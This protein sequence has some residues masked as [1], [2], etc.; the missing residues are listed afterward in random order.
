MII[1]SRLEGAVPMDLD[2]K[3]QGHAGPDEL[4][5]GDSEMC[6]PQTS[7]RAVQTETWMSRTAIAPGKQRMLVGLRHI[8]WISCCL[9]RQVLHLRIK[10]RNGLQVVILSS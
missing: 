6:Q 7:C 2:A 10:I 1:P 4:H 3:G 8:A 9:I 5:A